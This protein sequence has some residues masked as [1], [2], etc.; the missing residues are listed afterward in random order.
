MNAKQQTVDQI[1][2][3]KK[4]FLK[5]MVAAQPWSVYQ[6]KVLLCMVLQHSSLLTDESFAC[7]L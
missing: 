2:E 4:R 7:C 6:I 1:K 5:K 3:K